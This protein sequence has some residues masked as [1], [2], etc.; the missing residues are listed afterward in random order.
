[1]P[2]WSLPRC[3]KRDQSMDDISDFKCIMQYNASL[4]FYGFCKEF[5]SFLNQFCFLKVQIVRCG[6]SN[7]LCR[8]IF[9]ILIFSRI[10]YICLVLFVYF[11]LEQMSI[12]KSVEIICCKFHNRQFELSKSKIG[13]LFIHFLREVFYL[14]CEISSIDWSFLKH[15]GKLQIAKIFVY[16]MSVF[17]SSSTLSTELELL[18]ILMLNWA[19]YFHQNNTY[20]HK[21]KIMVGFFN[22]DHFY[23]NILKMI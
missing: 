17:Q 1:M 16:K 15:L 5:C 10:I 11:T 3:L 4:N 2:T 18:K 9:F 7:K 14:K 21:I 13:H 20:F 19:K 22:K 23:G 6:I 8:K 12:K